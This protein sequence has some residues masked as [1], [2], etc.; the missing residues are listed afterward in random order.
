MAIPSPYFALTLASAAMIGISSGEAA[1]A[2]PQ[3]PK[4]AP[5]YQAPPRPDDGTNMALAVQKLENGFDP[6]RPFLIWAIGSS[7]TNSL[8]NGNEL[9]GMIRERFPNA[10]R[11]EYKKMAG[12]STSYHFLRGWAQ[13]LVVPD[14]PDVVLMYNYGRTEELE[15]VIAMLRR[16]TT[17]DIIVPT[18]HWCKPHMAVWPKPDVRNSHQDPAGLREM[19]RK[20][21]VEFVES[22][23]E[24]TEYMLAH[25]LVPED[26]LRDSVHQNR[27]AA[28]MI[29]MNIARHFHRAA[30]ANYKPAQRERRLA[31]AASDQISLDRA[32]WSAVDGMPALK[33]ATPQ[34]T[35]TVRFTGTRLD[36]IGWRDPAGGSADVLI[37]GQPAGQAT[38]FYVNYVKPDRSNALKPPMPPRDRCPHAVGLGRNIVPQAWTITMLDDAGNFELTGSA[39]GPDGRGNSAKPFAGNSGQITIEPGLW[40]AANTNRKGDRFTFTVRR[41]VTMRIEFKGGRGKFRLSLAQ[42]LANGPHTVTLVTAGDGPATVEAFDVFEPP[43]KQ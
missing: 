24:L 31:V 34:S 6:D 39:T 7:F 20:H 36:L 37:D 32:Q 22:R 41:C 19:C 29:N 18:L 1:A 42:S 8:G 38:A 23:R 12:C 2:P 27:Y 10:P 3:P 25:K 14:Q 13:H 15:Q 5:E 28:K 40:R 11:I 4:G 17:A 16:R 30:S 33:A 9:I 35:V 21:G 26:L 43:L